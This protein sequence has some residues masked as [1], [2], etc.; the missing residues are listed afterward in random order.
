MNYSIATLNRCLITFNTVAA[1]EHLYLI[2][3]TSWVN[4]VICDDEH[5]L[6]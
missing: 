5:V 2:F 3:V 4:I 6:T 1:V